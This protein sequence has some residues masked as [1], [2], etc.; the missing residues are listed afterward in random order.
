M[1]KYS[2]E[3]KERWVETWKRSG[4]G[5]CAYAKANGLAPQTF[6]KRA[7]KETEERTFVEICPK[8]REERRI[9][10][11]I[12]IERGNLRIRLPLGTEGEDLRTVIELL[13]REV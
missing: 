6:N 1:T 11:E 2:Q 12:V 7:K 9:S 8:I 5:V 13:G 3:E 10:P 4:M